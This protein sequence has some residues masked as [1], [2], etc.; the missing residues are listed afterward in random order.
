MPTHAVSDLWYPLISSMLGECNPDC[1]ALGHKQGHTC[2]TWKALDLPTVSVA[3]PAH[4]VRSV[5]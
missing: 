3:S 1:T 5:T 4:K 2:L